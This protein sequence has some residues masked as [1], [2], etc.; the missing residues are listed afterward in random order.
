MFK[1]LKDHRSLYIVKDYFSQNA[2]G[3]R[4]RE[5]F[6]PSKDVESSSFDE[7]KVGKFWI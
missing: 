6:K 3:N 5:V 4:A 1:T 2:P 7:K